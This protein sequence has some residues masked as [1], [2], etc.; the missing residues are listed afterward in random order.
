MWLVR[1]GWAEER[2]RLGWRNVN[3]GHGKI[4]I[5]LQGLVEGEIDPQNE[6]WRRGATIGEA[7]RAGGT[8]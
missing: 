6:L 5:I 1:R 8:G 2:R 3:V 4:Q 7:G